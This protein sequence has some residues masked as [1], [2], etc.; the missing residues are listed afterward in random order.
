[1][2]KIIEIHNYASTGNLD[3]KLSNW[4]TLNGKITIYLDKVLR[5]AKIVLTK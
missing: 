3:T 1:M 5:K 2:P 4:K